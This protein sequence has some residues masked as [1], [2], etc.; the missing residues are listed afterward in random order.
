MPYTEG[1]GLRMYYE[2][3][4]DESHPPVVLLEGMGAQM[5]GWRDGFIAELLARDLRVIRMDNRDV[6]LSGMT[7]GPED[8]VAS[9]T[10]SDMAGDVCR[11][12]DSLGLASAHI[13]GQSMG[14]AIAQTMAIDHPDRVGS[15]VLVY[16]APAIEMALLTDELIQR[17]Q[18]FSPPPVVSREDAIAA[19]LENERLAGTS[20]YPS[21]E[22]WLRE[23]GGLSYDRGFRP[24]GI[25][26]QMS[27]LFTS[28][29]RREALGSLTMPTAIIHGREDRLV[30]A[31]ASIEMA[32]LIPQAELHLYP[33]M[34]HMV[35]EPLWSEFAEIIRR[36]VARA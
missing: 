22:A 36:T 32:Q 12:L 26:R 29:D 9:Y 8:R 4:G 16:T 11:V 19:F 15:L 13:V 14:G 21:N 25:H 3:E 20:A 18:E 33:G 5:I 17:S 7:G 34:G 6:G 35:V 10:L 24:D 27:V 30:K 28:G 1:E 2:A 23:L 31:Q